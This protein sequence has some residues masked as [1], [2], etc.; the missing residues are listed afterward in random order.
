MP[1][2]NPTGWKNGESESC[3]MCCT[4]TTVHRQEFFQQIPRPLTTLYQKPVQWWVKSLFDSVYLFV[5]SN[6][7]CGEAGNR[8]ICLSLLMSSG[9]YLAPLP[10]EFVALVSSCGF[11]CLLNVRNFW[12]WQ[13]DLWSTWNAA[14]IY[15]VQSHCFIVCCEP[16][17]AL[18]F[19]SVVYFG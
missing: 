13:I 5:G 2:L 6:T 15:V 1:A 11:L 7:I 12:K 9:V 10:P 17:T 18:E 14:V 4:L 3:E 19:I 8:R 16:S